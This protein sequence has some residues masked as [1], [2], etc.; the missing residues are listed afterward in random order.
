MPRYI[1]SYPIIV[2]A[3]N[4]DEA[5]KEAHRQDGFRPNR[6][7]VVGKVDYPPPAR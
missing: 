1:V 3:A 2:E 7:P 4:E 6:Q 5:V